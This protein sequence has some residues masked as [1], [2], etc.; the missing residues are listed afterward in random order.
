MPMGCI[1]PSNYHR[2]LL[3][4]TLIPIFLGSIAIAYYKFLGNGNIATVE[5]RNKIFSSILLGTFLI[6]PS[7]SI[8]IFSTF[9]CKEFEVSN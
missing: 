5:L 1:F 7:M 9:A 4:Y 2:M 6:L 3:G 8:K